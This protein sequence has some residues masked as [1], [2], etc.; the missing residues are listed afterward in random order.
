MGFGG[1]RPVG[2]GRRFSRRKTVK[3]AGATFAFTLI[4]LLVVIAIIAILAAMLLP[5][6]T[7]AKEKAKTM[8]CVN[9]LR[10]IGLGVIMYADDNHDTLPGPVYGL[11]VSPA[12]AG[13]F[14]L[15]TYLSSYLGNPN[16]TNLFEQIFMCPLNRWALANTNK[17][18]R[19]SLVVNA[20]GSKPPIFGYP[21]NP[22]YPPLKQTTIESIY[23]SLALNWALEDMDAWNYAGSV[24]PAPVHNGARNV[25]YMD[26]HV[27]TLKTATKT[28]IP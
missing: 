24:T 10:Q 25:L 7:R 18:S 5:A 23:G 22:Y 14:T 12:G 4:E 3:P 2:A 21:A 1:R 28:Q 6:L 19:G 17:Y 13:V 27:I 16:A 8:A 26:W 9:N 20:F 15:S 11:Q